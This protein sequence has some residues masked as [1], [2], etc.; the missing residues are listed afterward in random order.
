MYTVI[1]WAQDQ[2]QEWAFTL[3]NAG[4]YYF[5]DRAELA[6]LNEIDWNAVQ[7]RDWR[8]P[9]FK[10][11]KQA[12]FLVESAVD[13]SLVERIGVLSQAVGQQAL[14]SLRTGAHQP[15]VQIIRDW[16]Y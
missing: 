5:E 11:A 1:Q 6:Q 4:A 12:E 7:A 14:A 8:N 15:T 9:D 3:S 13:W 2:G 16:Y 10:H